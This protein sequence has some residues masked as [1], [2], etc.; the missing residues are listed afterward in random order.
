MAAS[1]EGLTEELVGELARALR[2]RIGPEDVA[3]VRRLL[4]MQLDANVGTAPNEPA[5]RFEAAWN[6]R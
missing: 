1:E 4:S 6:E 3:G 2:I 5:T